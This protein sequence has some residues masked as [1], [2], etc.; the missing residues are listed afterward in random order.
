MGILAQ[1]LPIGL[2]L[3]TLPCQAKGGEGAKM[4][5]KEI[6]MIKLN[7]VNNDSDVLVR[8]LQDSEEISPIRTNF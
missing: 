1:V 3:L 7:Q 2:Q 5:I 4:P 6:L 8:I